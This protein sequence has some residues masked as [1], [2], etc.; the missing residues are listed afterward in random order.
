MQIVDNLN[1]SIE[2]KNDLTIVVVED[3]L[4]NA[5]TLMSNINGF[6]FKKF[7]REKPPAKSSFLTEQDVIKNNFYKHDDF[8]E[9]TSNIFDKKL[10]TDPSMF[11]QGIAIMRKGD[12]LDKHF[13]KPF[14]PNLKRHR[15]INLLIYLGEYDGG[16]FQW[17][18]MRDNVLWDIKVKHNSALLFNYNKSSQHGV[19]EIE[20]GQRM[21]LRHFYY[22]NRVLSEEEMIELDSEWRE[23]GYDNS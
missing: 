19:S 14:N 8:L 9:F 15:V 17:F 18:D 20:S 21:S 12:F 23:G 6:E 10:I 4:D 11:G 16:I 1:F 13:D 5:D 7:I 22:E 3:I 2:D